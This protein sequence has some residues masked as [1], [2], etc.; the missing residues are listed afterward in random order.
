MDWSYDLLA[1]SE[2][3]LF[4]RLSVFAGGFTLE[5]AEQVGA[6]GG[7]AADDVLD[8]LTCLVDKSLV[9]VAEQPDETARYGLLETLR[10]YARERLVVG[11]EE[12]AVRDRHAAHFVAQAEARAGRVHGA[13]TLA[14]RD[15]GWFAREPDNVRAA[16]GWLRDRG[17][18]AGGLRLGAFLDAAWLARGHLSEGRAWLAELL[19]LPAAVAPAGLR[20]RALVALARLARH[21]GD[22]AAARGG[23]AEG[24]AAA[25][26]A[27]DRQQEVLV[28]HYLAELALNT[29]DLT[30]ARRGAAGSRPR[31]RR[32]A[33]PTGRPTSTACWA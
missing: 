4:A 19:A 25:R 28:L 21:Q 11:G 16:L 31:P 30:A 20:A 14:E 13:R 24:L 15:F 18:A 9:V 8:L 7:I 1:E 5:A 2:R 33:T 23:F 29:G 26:A 10:Q 6:G 3:A 17:D 12:D 32:W 27:G 22:W